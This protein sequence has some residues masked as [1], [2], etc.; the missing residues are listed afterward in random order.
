MKKVA[1][2]FAA[3]SIIFTGMAAVDVSAEEHEVQNNDSLWG[4]ANQYDTS[5]QELQDLNEL[6]STVIVPGQKIQVDEEEKTDDV[7]K[8]EKGDTLSAIAADYSVKVKEIKDWNDLSSDI[9][10]IGQE[11]TIKG[12]TVEQEETAEAEEQAPAEEE[13]QEEAEP[14]EE[15]T[16]DNANNVEDGETMTVTATAYTG[17]CEGCSGVTSTGID[18]NAN[19]DE[20]VI[21]VDPDVIP[22]G[23]KVHVEGY[24]DAVAGDIGGAI[25]GDKIDV[26]LPTKEEANQWGVQTVEVTIL[27]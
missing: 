11:L 24:G 6:D 14:V 13:K 19:P 27:D 16:V 22:L 12:A 5:V 25:K 8:V 7:Y 17:K 20:K 3:T 10:Q 9:I 21:A 15:D 18:L 4:I 2:A 1:V 26:H 23:T